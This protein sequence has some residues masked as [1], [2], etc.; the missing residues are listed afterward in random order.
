[1]GSRLTSSSK[2][3]VHHIPGRTRLRLPRTH[4]NKEKLERVQKALS[5]VPGVHSVEVNHKTGSVLLHHDP[6]I[7]IFEAAGSALE[8]VG[9]DILESIVEGESLAGMGFAI[10]GIALVGRVVG[11]LFGETDESGQTRIRLWRGQYQDLRQ[12]LPVTL[13]GA[14]IYQAIK[15]RTMWEGI[16][17]LVLLYWAFDSYWKLNMQS[18]GVASRDGHLDG[19]QADDRVNLG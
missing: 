5:G 11:N 16:A 1:M 6:A 15:T 12:L 17:P 4:R 7:A 18:Y 13:F 3:V 10:A 2:G 14:A 8:D 19:P 9:K